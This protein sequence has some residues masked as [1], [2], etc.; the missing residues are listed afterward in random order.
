MAKKKKVEKIGTIDMVKVV[1][2][3]YDGAMAPF[4][5]GAHE[6]EKDKPRRKMKPRD[7]RKEEW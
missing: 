7:Y 2:D 5:F 4:R 1:R 3:S 6:T